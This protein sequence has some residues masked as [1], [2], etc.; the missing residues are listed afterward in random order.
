MFLDKYVNSSFDR[1]ASKSRE[2][3]WHFIG[4]KLLTS[5]LPGSSWRC[6]LLRLFGSFIGQGVVIKPRVRLKFPWKLYVSDYCWL[7]EGVWIDNI[8]IVRINSHVCVSQGVYIC[9]GSHDWTKSTFDLIVKPVVICSHAWLC[10]MSKV[11]P[12]VTVEEGAVLGFGS[13]ATRN[14]SAWMI[15]SGNP[16]VIVRTRVINDAPSLLN[17]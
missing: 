12:G 9:T 10:A 7:G 3:L 13:V 17:L 14:L 6:F 15:Y 8:D 4:A 16:A 2:V 5:S 1:G 11:A